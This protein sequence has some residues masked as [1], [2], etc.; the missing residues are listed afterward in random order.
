MASVL[1]QLLI[2]MAVIGTACLVAATL[3]RGDD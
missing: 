3:D 1:A 2:L